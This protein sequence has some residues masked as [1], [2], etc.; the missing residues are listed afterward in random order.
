MS[1]LSLTLHFFFRASG[2]GNARTSGYEALS[3]YMT[4]API[5]CM[6]VVSKL[7]VVAVERAEG[8]LA[9]QGQ[10]LGADDKL[11]YEEVQMSLCG[12]LTVRLR[13]F[14][15]VPC[16][17]VLELY[18]TLCGAQAVIRR[19][20]SEVKPIADRIMT[21]LL[22]L[23]QNAGKSSTIMEDAFLCV[24]AM[25]TSTSA[26]HQFFRAARLTRRSFCSP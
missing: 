5:D 1:A 16:L 25:I 8:L 7:A 10:F 22:H 6:P 17:H 26:G 4:N 3:A 21:L 14:E 15:S 23:V 9:M 18:L 13:P 11:N 19:L 12:L 24:G 2:E 20:G